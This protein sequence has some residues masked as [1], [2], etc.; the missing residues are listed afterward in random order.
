MDVRACTYYMYTHIYVYAGGLGKQVEY[1]VRGRARR[2][3]GCRRALRRKGWRAA[4]G[5]GERRQRGWGRRSAR[6]REGS[7]KGVSTSSAS[8]RRRRPAAFIP[9]CIVCTYVARRRQRLICTKIIVL[10]GRASRL[11]EF[12]TCVVCTPPMM[13]YTLPL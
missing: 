5:G 3:E 13:L 1:W 11:R 4:G 8:P 2:R 12:N 9:K 6:R 10:N 7:I